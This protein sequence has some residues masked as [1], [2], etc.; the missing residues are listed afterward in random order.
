MTGG[1]GNCGFHRLA[2]LCALAGMLGILL[3][4]CRRPAQYTITFDTQGG[5]GIPPVTGKAGTTVNEPVPPA[6]PDYS[7]QGWYAGATGSGAKYGEWPHTLKAD[8]TLYAH[9]LPLSPSDEDRLAA[10]ELEAA[11][12]AELEAKAAEAARQAAAKA[13]AAKLAEAEAE[14]AK[15]A[16]VEAEAAK[17]AAAEAEAAKLAA[18][19]AEAAKQAAAEAEAARRA[20]AELAAAAAEAARRAELEAEAAAELR[21][22]EL[23]AA[24]LAAAEAAGTEAA[25][26]AYPGPDE[27]GEP[28]EN[29]TREA[30]VVREDIARVPE[31][32]I[33]VEPIGGAI[34]GIPGQPSGV[35]AMGSG[36]RRF[37]LGLL[38]L[39]L[40]AGSF[41]QKDWG[42]GL[43]VLA[44]YA[45]AG[46]LIAWELTLKYE[47]NIAGVPGT[48]GLGVAAAAAL[49][50]FV[51]PFFFNRSRPEAIPP[52]RVNFSVVP[53]ERGAAVHL[54]YTLQF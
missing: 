54:S 29:I 10:A 37:S 35:P 4:G 44:A 20:V 34:T 1:S 28:M 21:A 40:G 27:A 18:A 31:P 14:T 47:D 3:V 32:P 43:T 13:E 7:F 11:R 45:A 42:G 15:L 12:R 25:L 9:W 2:L 46:G 50:G 48:V 49:F 33:A 26:R 30:P 24:E 8:V 38:N 41:V 17:Q 5:S 53:G 23:M 22:A 39:A 52:K 6:R 51:R 16:A 19:E 36:G